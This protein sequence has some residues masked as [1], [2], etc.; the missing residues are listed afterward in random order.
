[1]LDKP[2]SYLT[3]ILHDEA[4][5][6]WEGTF[7]PAYVLRITSLGQVTPHKNVSTSKALSEFFAERLKAPNTRGYII[8]ND[9]GRDFIGYKGTTFGS[10]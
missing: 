2:K 1:M 10:M 8:F 5:M 9:P 7:D 4:K 3:V 6:A